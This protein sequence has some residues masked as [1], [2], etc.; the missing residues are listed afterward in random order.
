MYLREQQTGSKHAASL[1]GLF[2][3]WWCISEGPVDH[4]LTLRLRSRFT[5]TLRE[6]C[7]HTTVVVNA[8]H[9]QAASSCPSFC[10]RG[11]V[12]DYINTAVCMS[13]FEY[14]KAAADIENS[15]ITHLEKDVS[16]CCSWAS[17]HGVKSGCR[18]G[19]TPAAQL[20]A[21]SA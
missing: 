21:H 2:C 17:V 18:F 13:V 16:C 1:H 10:R 8:I 14:L 7:I 19:I 5:E 12:N 11:Q 9:G 4:A 3:W 20:C 15:L 6:R